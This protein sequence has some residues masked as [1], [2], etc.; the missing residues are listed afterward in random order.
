MLVW[1]VQTGEPVPLPDSPGRP[2]RSMNLARA[3]V[4]S[5][6]EVV[7]WG[8]DFSHT[9]KQHFFGRHTRVTVEPGY[10][11][12][13][14]HSRGYRKN[15]SPARMLD[16]AQLAM[17]LR[18]QLAL[19]A[20]LPDVAVVGFP[21]IE[22]AY[23]ATKWLT[24]RDVPVLLDVKDRWPDLFLRAA[25][26]VLQPAGRAAL[27]PYFAL[28]HSTMR[29][30][31]GLSSMTDRFLDW[32]LANVGRPRHAADGV[33]PLTVAQMAPDEEELHLADDW[34]S[35]KGV[36]LDG[37]PRI[38]FVGTLNAA[39]DFRPVVDAARVTS[40]EFVI[41][42]S[43]SQQEEVQGILSGLP[44]VKMPGWITHPQ[45]EVLARNSQLALGPYVP[46]PDFQDN[47]PNKIYDA[48]AHGQPF[49]SSL[50]GA[51]EENIYANSA[52][53]RYTIQPG[54]RS[55]A[56]VLRELEADPSTIQ[57][58]SAAAADLYETRFSF[59][60]VYGRMV[61]HLAML[62]EWTAHRGGE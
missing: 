55:L 51:I 15:V 12:Q 8:S 56:N 11:L 28:A 53:A 22:P 16:H 23:A 31:T 46:T 17:A 27:S 21:P 32:C 1:I 4:D 26:E 14:V 57:Q 58:M 5:G 61:Q 13:L 52:G 33:F 60:L 39:F 37:R 25:P 38:S 19:D 62:S 49:I 29:Q 42:G 30:A 43:G 54:P 45:A 40:F 35:S 20:V 50:T 44:N 3:L 10:Q 59:D 6:H 2:M 36:G 24:Q 18:R 41:A 7:I 34:W 48:L 47:I 9:E